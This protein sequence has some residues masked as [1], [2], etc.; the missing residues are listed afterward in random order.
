MFLRSRSP[1]PTFLLSYHVRVTS[2]I[3]VNFR[4]NRYS[5]VLMCLIDSHSFFTIHV[6]EVKE[7][8]PD[9]TGEPPCLNNPENLGQLP[10]QEDLRGTD[11]FVLWIFTISSKLMFSRSR[12]PFLT[13]L[14]GYHVCVTSKIKVNFRFTRY[15]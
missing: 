4:F 1:L 2:K 7:S 13:F 12:N 9:I 8:I 3:Q 6:F 14:L 11:D 10:V 5:K 15:C